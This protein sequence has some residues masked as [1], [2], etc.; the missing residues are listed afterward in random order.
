MQPP[1]WLLV[2]LALLLPALPAGAQPQ[3]LSA[4]DHTAIRTVIERQIEA[5]RNDDAVSAFAFASP[6]IQEQFGT[7]ENFMHMVRVAYPPVYRP[8]HVVFK[9]LR[10]VRGVPTQPVLLVGPDGVLVMALYPMAKQ[11][12]G[13]WK[14][15]GCYLMSFKG[16]TL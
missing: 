16:E 7:P 3:A 9:A 1:R 11:S 6:M 12:D 5:F 8:R 13:T 4:T 15:D 14:V 10:V 2:V